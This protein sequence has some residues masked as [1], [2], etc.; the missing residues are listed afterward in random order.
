[1]LIEFI[2]EQVMEGLIN[3]R[4]IPTESNIADLLTKLIVSKTFTIKAMH[5]L[6]E[7]GMSLN[8]NKSCDELNFKKE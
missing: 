3:L 1:M 4:K 6:G 8:V 2:R 7:M 5:L